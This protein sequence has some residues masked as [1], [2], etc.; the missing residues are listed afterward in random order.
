MS[1][2]RISFIF[3]VHTVVLACRQLLVT[4]FSSEMT[5]SNYSAVN[6]WFM[7]E[8]KNIV[9]VVVAVCF[10][11]L[12]CVKCDEP[13][14]FSW[15]FEFSCKLIMIPNR[16]LWCMHFQ[17][18]RNMLTSVYHTSRIQ[19]VSLFGFM[20]YSVHNRSLSRWVFPRNW[21]YWFNH[22]NCVT[23]KHAWNTQTFDTNSWPYTNMQ[24]KN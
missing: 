23:N 17:L 2:S 3:Y 12:F 15:T 8:V 13:F 6:V 5:V 4:R 10:S 18:K 16:H 11:N 9:M 1:V 20:S 7:Y 19:S 21:L 22:Q 14:C 24:N